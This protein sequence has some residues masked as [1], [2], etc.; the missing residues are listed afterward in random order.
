[1]L[2]QYTLEIDAHRHK[3]SKKV[4]PGKKKWNV[5][6]SDDGSKH[7]KKGGYKGHG[8][9]GGYKE[10]PG[11]RKKGDG[12]HRPGKKADSDCW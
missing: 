11:H 5:G 3:K 12:K 2:L 9:K 10:E 7:G 6:K 1:M 4:T 8:K